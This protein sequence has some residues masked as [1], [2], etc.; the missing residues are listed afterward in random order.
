MRDLFEGEREILSRSAPQREHLSSRTARDIR[1]LDTLTRRVAY[2]TAPD[3]ISVRG[4]RCRLEVVD[5]SQGKKRCARV[6]SMRL[7]NDQFLAELLKNKLAGTTAYFV[8]GVRV[9]LRE[10]GARWHKLARLIKFVQ[11]A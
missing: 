3:V 6:R 8:D 9:Q 10:G 5:K 4:A 2:S 11:S 1:I 7:A